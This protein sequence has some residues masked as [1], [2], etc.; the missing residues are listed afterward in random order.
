MAQPFGNGQ[1]TVKKV[2]KNAVR[3]QYTEKTVRDTMPDWLYV[4]H[5]EVGNDLQVEVDN[6]HW[7]LVVKTPDGKPVFKATRHQME[8]GG[9][10]LVPLWTRT[11]PGRLS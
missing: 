9:A 8:N 11:V 1:V 4:N 10:S 7:T 3:V 6:T 5:E 2:A